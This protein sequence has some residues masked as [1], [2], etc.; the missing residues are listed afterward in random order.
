MTSSGHSIFQFVVPDVSDAEQVLDWR[1]SPR[2]SA[3]MLSEVENNLEQQRAWLVGVAERDDYAHWLIRVNN[4]N[5]GIINVTNLGD[6]I[7][8]WGYYIGEEGYIGYGGLIPPYLYNHLFFDR[9]S[10]KIVGEVFLSNQTVAAMHKKH[11]YQEL[12]RS[13]WP[14]GAPK[15][16]D[17]LV[18]VA[19]S[20]ESWM[21]KTFFHKYVAQFP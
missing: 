18:K 11:G 9:G 2:I 10:A 8:T 1:T 17:M 14:D 15:P 13:D 4:Q 20:R 6:D 21:N 5:I 16:S 19:L 7:Y 3:V 12:G